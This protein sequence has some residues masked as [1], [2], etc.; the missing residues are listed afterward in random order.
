MR[1]LLS[2]S[3][4]LLV[5]A[6]P[7]GRVDTRYRVDA[8][9]VVAMDD[10]EEPGVDTL[11]ATA[12]IRLSMADSTVGSIASFVVESAQFRHTT[13]PGSSPNFEDDP[14]ATG[15]KLRLHVVPGRTP[16]VLS[17]TRGPGLGSKSVIG[18]GNPPG[19]VSAYVGVAVREM[20]PTLR[21]GAKSGD[22]WTDTTWQTGATV[23]SVWTIGKDAAGVLDIQVHDSIS[24]SVDV[25]GSH[26]ASAAQIWRE[27]KSSAA[28]P[29]L[30][31]SVREKRSSTIADPNE[32][33]HLL[34]IS[35][36]RTVSIVRQE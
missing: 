16:T 31:A 2:V 12:I 19:R 18:G 5:G 30:R 4:L 32:K 6:R 29:L 22:R 11:Y 10:G 9:E 20:F 23:V 25:D 3:L 7:S 17:N 1:L 21:L 14:V 34:T 26:F 28:G 24:T 27:L 33:P 35:N 15:T 36:T 13:G 8:E